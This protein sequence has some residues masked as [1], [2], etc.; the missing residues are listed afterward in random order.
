MERFKITIENTE[1]EKELQRTLAT[2][3]STKAGSQPADREFG[4]SWE[5]LDEVPEAAEN[6]FYL[7][8]VRKVEKY[9]PRVEIKNIIFQQEEGVMMPHIYFTG[10][11]A[12]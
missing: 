6:L 9:E 10:R 1:N 5:C 2:L 7:E 4:I 3:F 11:G 12:E 8:A